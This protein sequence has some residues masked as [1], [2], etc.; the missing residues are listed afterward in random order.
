MYLSF[1]FMKSRKKKIDW[2]KYILTGT[3]ALLI[4][5]ILGVVAEKTSKAEI[6]KPRLITTYNCQ[7]LT[8]TQMFA[9]KEYEGIPV[10]VQLEGVK[11]CRYSRYGCKDKV[12]GIYCTIQARDDSEYSYMV[13][14]M[15]ENQLQA[16][17]GA[18]KT[19]FHEVMYKDRLGNKTI[20]H[21]NTDYL[22]D[23]IGK[24]RDGYEVNSLG[25]KKMVKCDWDKISE[26]FKYNVPVAMARGCMGNDCRV[27]AEK[28][29]ME[30]HLTSNEDLYFAFQ[31][32]WKM[33]DLPWGQYPEKS[34]GIRVRT[35]YQDKDAPYI[36]KRCGMIVYYD[37]YR[38]QFSTCIRQSTL[39]EHVG[40]GE[41]KTSDNWKID[42]DEEPITK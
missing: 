3:L 11:E 6:E 13:F 35:H 18:A 15:Y 32:Y 16:N 8:Q 34:E 29:E 42:D 7:M 33:P 31:K 20:C 1:D 39:D 38:A 4:G 40:I 22:G 19:H 37:I 21:F 26:V 28:E 25:E 9:M 36:I 2:S 41:M 17:M 5:F 12:N 27:E 23:V 10:E 24:I 30:F 14:P